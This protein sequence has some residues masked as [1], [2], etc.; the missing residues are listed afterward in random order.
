M[1]S[2]CMEERERKRESGSEQVPENMSIFAARVMATYSILS[3]SLL[4]LAFRSSASS[5]FI[6][7]LSSVLRS[8]SIMSQAAPSSG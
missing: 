3:S 5:S 8:G 2:L 6:L 7:D 1:S 4:F